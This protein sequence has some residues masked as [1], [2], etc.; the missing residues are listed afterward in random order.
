MD[1]IQGNSLL[2][3][4]GV[5]GVEGNNELSARLFGSAETANKM[6]GL[7]FDDLDHMTYD[8]IIATVREKLG[9]TAFNVTWESGMQMCLEEAIAYAVKE[10]K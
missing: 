6:L 5:A 3:F 1:S 8:P 10:L 2:G 7:N 4:A 9:E